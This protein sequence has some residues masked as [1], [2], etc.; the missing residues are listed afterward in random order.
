MT[1]AGKV[2]S[3]WTPLTCHPIPAPLLTGR[4]EGG[5]YILSCSL[6]LLFTFPVLPKLPWLK[7]T[8]VS[9]LQDRF[10][11]LERRQ[12]CQTPCYVCTSAPTI[13]RPQETGTERLTCSPH[14]AQALA[15]NMRQTSIP[16][17]LKYCYVNG[18]FGW[19]R[20][21]M[22]HEELLPAK[23]LSS[24]RCFLQKSSPSFQGQKLCCSYILEETCL[25]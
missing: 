12:I 3:G 15:A 23:T 6:H 19:I 14:L 2:T 1:A 25:L 10:H 7:L 22:W 5:F 17:P 21:T 9:S 8:A 4:K 18:K 16:F 20:Q 24:G 13:Q 11:K